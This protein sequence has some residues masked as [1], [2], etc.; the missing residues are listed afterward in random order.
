MRMMQKVSEETTKESAIVGTQ[1]TARQTLRFWLMQSID[2][3][4]DDDDDD[5]IFPLLLII[6]IF[7]IIVC[8][9]HLF[10]VVF[11]SNFY[12]TVLFFFFYFSLSLSLSLSL[13]AVVAAAALH[14]AFDLCR[15]VCCVTCGHLS[16]EEHPSWTTPTTVPIPSVSQLS[17]CP[18]STVNKSN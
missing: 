7:I 18:H 6:I 13:V 14:T 2:N 16:Y 9:I 1:P 5:T 8:I 10:S 11:P 4:N 17:R 3:N 15:L 12:S